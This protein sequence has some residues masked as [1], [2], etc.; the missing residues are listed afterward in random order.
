M[1]MQR[2]LVTRVKDAPPREFIFDDAPNADGSEGRGASMIA[3]LQ[4]R[5]RRDELFAV[6]VEPA[7]FDP[8][9]E[10]VEAAARRP[11]KKTAESAEA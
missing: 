7:V 1:T 2:V 9:A 6:T 4:R 3:S 5:V 11:A 10:L 8:P